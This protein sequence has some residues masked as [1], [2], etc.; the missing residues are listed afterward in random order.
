[1]INKRNTIKRAPIFVLQKHQ[2]KTL[3][4]DFRLEKAGVLKSWV[5]PKGLPNKKGEK[6]LAIEVEDHQIDFADYEGTIPEGEYGAG[7][8]K[9][10]DTGYYE[11]DIWT[12]NKIIIHL[13]GS[14]ISGKFI[15]LKTNKLGEINWIIIKL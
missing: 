3:H 13:K 8:I 7:T 12:I 2:A 9:I 5:V 6:R 4:Y 11:L 14:T 1:M 10:I 15:L